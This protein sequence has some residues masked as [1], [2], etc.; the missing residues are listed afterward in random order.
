MITVEVFYIFFVSSEMAQ[1]LLLL[2]FA[3]LETLVILAGFTTVRLRA[4]CRRSPRSSLAP[5]AHLFVSG[6]A[7]QQLKNVATGLF[8]I[9]AEPFRTGVDCHV[10]ELRGCIERVSLARTTLRRRDGAL[11]YIPN[12]IF[13]DS[14]QTNGHAHDAQLHELALTVHPST[15]I[16]R[17]QQ[18]MDEL[19][20][21]LPQ[22]AVV[23]AAVGAS[24]SAGTSTSSSRAV[25]FRNSESVAAGAVTPPLE[26]QSFVSITDMRTDDRSSVRV[27]LSAM[28]RVQV[29]VLVDRVRFRTLEAAKTEVRVACAMSIRHSVL[30][31]CPGIASA[32]DLVVC[33]CGCGCGRST[34]RSSRVSSASVSSRRSNAQRGSDSRVQLPMICS[35]A[36][37]TLRQ[38]TTAAADGASQRCSRSDD[39][40]SDRTSGDSTARD[41]MATSVRQSLHCAAGHLPS[42]L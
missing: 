28:Y 20:V 32:A 3:S 27:V 16:D 25:S 26:N 5:L 21:I 24:G 18:L 4:G 37:Q 13:A 6:N 22:F 8:L 1:F 38:Q 19:A 2:I 10:R 40:G 29:S 9:F 36:C 39:D 35:R 34:S 30:C 15:P 11:V 31:C 23:D 7:L 42:R 12:G 33:V 41:L 14:H 17:I